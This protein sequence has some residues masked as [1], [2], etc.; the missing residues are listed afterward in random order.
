MRIYPLYYIVRRISFLDIKRILLFSELE[1]FNYILKLNLEH[2]PKLILTSILLFCIFFKYHNYKFQWL[3]CKV[4]H[5]R[6]PV[7]ESFEALYF[8]LL[9][10][11]LSFTLSVKREMRSGML[12]F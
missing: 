1:I 7:Y 9:K 4:L 12:I 5:N 6:P 10:L 8:R 2:F 11:Y 3:Y